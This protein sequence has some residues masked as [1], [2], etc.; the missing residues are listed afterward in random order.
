M[1]RREAV[2]A[3]LTPEKYDCA[4]IQE[5]GLT[6]SLLLSAPPHASGTVA[7][8]QPKSEPV[9]APGPCLELMP[10]AW[11]NYALLPGV[12]S[13]DTMHARYQVTDPSISMFNTSMNMQLG[14]HDAMGDL[15]VPELQGDWHLETRGTLSQ[16]GQLPLCSFKN[17]VET[18]GHL[19]PRVQ[20]LNNKS[21]EVFDD[22]GPSHGKGDFDQRSPMLLLKDAVLK[23]VMAWLFNPSEDINDE[24]SILSSVSS[25]Q[26][27][28]RNNQV[29]A[30]LLS[31]SATLTKATQSL[32]E[33]LGTRTN[34][35]VCDNIV[36]H[37]LVVVCHMH[38]FRSFAAVL[39]AL[40][41]GA[42]VIQGDT[43]P[44]LADLRLAM[45]VQISSYLFVRQCRVVDG[46]LELKSGP[47]SS[48]GSPNKGTKDGRVVQQL[49]ALVDSRLAWFQKLWYM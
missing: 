5:P 15:C 11:P 41:D 32:H 47:N 24:C 25:T 21:Q 34:S 40:Q 43:T 46:Y 4:S 29:V 26:N 13:W 14:F 48:A 8:S 22:W 37:H 17:A 44:G 23:L 2:V 36:A 31:C 10:E 7:P 27:E 20:A 39:G 1:S 28:L 45:V 18:L 38:L 9:L 30:E 6:Y 49:K 3:P 33:E 19:T 16:V 12:Y 35:A 42:E